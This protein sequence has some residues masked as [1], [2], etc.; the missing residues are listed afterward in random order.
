MK[1]D[2]KHD[3]S[4]LDFVRPNTRCLHKKRLVFATVCA[5]TTTVIFA[6]KLKKLPKDLRKY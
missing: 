2:N 3:S 5:V 6:K 1:N 4:N